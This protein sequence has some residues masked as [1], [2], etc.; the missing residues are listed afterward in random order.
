MFQDL[1]PNSFAAEYNSLSRLSELKPEQRKVGI[2]L[3]I[4]GFVLICITWF[5]SKYGFT[6]CEDHLFP[7]MYIFS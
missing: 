1:S 6:V 7:T 5:C 2:S 3:Y 4:V